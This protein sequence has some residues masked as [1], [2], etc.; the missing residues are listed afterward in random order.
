MIIRDPNSNQA[1][2]INDKGEGNTFSIQ[3]S[4]AQSAA[5]DNLAYNI[6][7]GDIGCAG[8][9]T[10]IY[11]KND[12]DTDMIVESFAVGVRGSTITDMATVTLIR[13]PTGGDLI[14]DA[15]AVDMKVN[16]NFGTSDVLKTTTLAYKGKVNGTIT[17]GTD[18]AQFYIGNNS[19]LFA[20]VNL[21]IPR[22]SSMALKIDDTTTGG[23]AY[24]ALVVHLKD[25]KR[26]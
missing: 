23:N 1:M 8:N 11:V 3:K 4:E 12:E 14:S 10:L 24:A 18:S 2:N 19:R 7:T 26:S 22:G 25:E 6:N 21:V 20:D 13:N 9:T 5:E 17:G 15:T 16:R